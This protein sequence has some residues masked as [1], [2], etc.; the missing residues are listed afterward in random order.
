M[1]TFQLTM[2]F[3]SIGHT[4]SSFGGVRR[5]KRQLLELL[6]LDLGP[7]DAPIGGVVETDVHRE[8]RAHNA[9]EE[10][11]QI[12]V[13]SR[14]MN[15]AERVLEREVLAAEGGADAV[16]FPR[17]SMGENHMRGEVGRFATG[18]S[19]ARGWRSCFKCVRAD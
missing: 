10:A 5:R 18:A 8:R 4:P 6:L 3:R 19:D 13:L 14:A 12:F 1:E 15:A 2:E 16:R 9:G 11:E 7:F 17:H